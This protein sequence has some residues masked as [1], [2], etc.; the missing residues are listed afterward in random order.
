ML[1]EAH[2]HATAM[3]QRNPCRARCSVEQRVEQRPVRHGI[4][5]ITHGFRLAVG[6]GDGATI[7]VVAADHDRRLEFTPGDHF[8]ERE[9][10]AVTVAQ[11]DPADA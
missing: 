4:R 3:V 11:S 2:A 10:K 8:I 5:A 9:A 1:R 6:A 7:E